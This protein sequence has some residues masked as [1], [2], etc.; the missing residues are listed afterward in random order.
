MA[1]ECEAQLGNLDKAEE[2][3]NRVRDRAANKDGW[4]YKYNDPGA[5]LG[6][7]STIPAADYFIMAYSTGEFATNG[8]DYA[9]KAIYFERKLELAMEGYRFFDLAR[10]G[11]AD[12]ALN[13]YIEYENKIT[14]DLLIAHFTKGKNEYYPIPQSEIDLGTVNGKSMLIQNPEY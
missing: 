2:Y 11:I 13:A 12:K 8:K 4:V 9:L 7:F 3:V 14:T 1:A 6:G 10:W 5:P